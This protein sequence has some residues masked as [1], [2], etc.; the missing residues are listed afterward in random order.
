M[1]RFSA[2]T[3]SIFRYPELDTGAFPDACPN[4][5]FFLNDTIISDPNPCISRMHSLAN[6]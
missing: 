5:I 3:V 6:P 4:N 2:R 1:A